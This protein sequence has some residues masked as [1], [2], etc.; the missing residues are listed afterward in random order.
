M[1]MRPSPCNFMYSWVRNI[2]QYVRYHLTL[3][4]HHSFYVSF[5]RGEPLLLC[6][7]EG[8]FVS[9]M[10]MMMMMMFWW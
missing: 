6:Q 5:N 1:H 10:M 4:H 8:K 9:W 3:P 2:K 7:W